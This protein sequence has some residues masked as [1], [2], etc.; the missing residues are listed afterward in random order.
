MTDDNIRQIWSDAELDAALA[1]LHDDVGDGD[2]TFARTSL[3][4]AAGAEPETPPAP[5]ESRGAWRWIAVAAAVAT[6]TGGLVVAT[7]LT[8]RDPAPAPIAPAAT[9]P[10]L[11]DLRGVDLPIGPGEFRLTTSSSWMAADKGANPKT[12]VGMQA[13]LW[14]PADPAGDWHLR[15]TLTNTP[16][17]LQV[18]VPRLEPVPV[19][20]TDT[21]GAGGIFPGMYGGPDFQGSWDAPTALFV[22]SL[23]AD[24]QALRAQLTNAQAGVGTP[25]R[26]GEENSPGAV[27]QMVRKTLELGLARGDVRVALWRALAGVEGIVTTPGM[28]SPDGRT[29]IGFTAKDGGTLIADQA[30]AQLIG[31][32]LPLKESIGGPGIQSS[33]VVPPDSSTS[34]EPRVPIMTTIPPPHSPHQPAEEQNSMAESYTYSIT[35]TDH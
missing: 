30:T 20:N 7:Q 28:P 10:G 27:V 32:T 21:T 5:A 14:I 12:Y 22:T 29:G 23:P 1:D 4:A 33:E 2:L 11:D 3:L 34:N 31:Y 17:G 8:N 15:S 6:L 19:H 9:L 25:V 24:V 26:R 18:P 13:R 16:T 35:K